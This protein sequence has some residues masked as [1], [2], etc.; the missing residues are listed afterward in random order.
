MTA[1]FSFF[2]HTMVVQSIIQKKI[3]Q[4]Q[5]WAETFLT[6]ENVKWAVGA[7][8]KLHSSSISTTCFSF[9]VAL[10]SHLYVCDHKV[11]VSLSVV[12]PVVFIHFI[13]FHYIKD[14]KQLLL[15]VTNTNSTATN[16]YSK[17]G[18]MVRQ[19]ANNTSEILQVRPMRQATATATATSAG[20]FPL[21]CHCRWNRQ[22]FQTVHP[23]MS[24]K[25][26]VSSRIKNIETVVLKEQRNILHIQRRV[27]C[28]EKKPRNI[29]NVSY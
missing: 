24:S 15:T 8:L 18:W 10:P 7:F 23:I 16:D 17:P 12:I 20:A 21:V 14:D 28:K 29:D 26:K 9:N 13:Q 4:Q 3:H 27:S 2:A 19:P 11:L 25:L 6:I 5:R 22:C 1:H